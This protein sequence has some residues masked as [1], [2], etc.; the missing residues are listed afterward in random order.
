MTMEPKMPR[1]LFHYT[2]LEGHDG[3]LKSKNIRPSLRANN[4]KDARHGDGQYFSDILPNTR[5]PAELSRIFFGFPWGGKRFA[6]HIDVNVDG[7]NVM[8]GRPFVFVR[9]CAGSAGRG[10]PATAGI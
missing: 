10:D 7:L 3:I 9:E 6:Y 8:A 5:R 1:T 4:P 2:S